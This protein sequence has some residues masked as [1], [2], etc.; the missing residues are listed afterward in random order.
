MD[1]LLIIFG[2][3]Y[4]S[5]QLY[6]SRAKESGSTKQ[7]NQEH[8]NKIAVRWIKFC[9]VISW[10]LLV[11]LFMNQ[12]FE[13]FFLYTLARG[14]ILIWL[15]YNNAYGASVLFDF[16]TQQLQKISPFIMEFACNALD[17]KIG[18]DVQFKIFFAHIVELFQEQYNQILSSISL[19]YPQ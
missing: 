6:Y 11:T 17:E 5:F 16:S 10:Y 12:V 7:K 1:L 14:V 4:G 3:L 18:V 19:E 2:L 13:G 15:M 8:W 9:C